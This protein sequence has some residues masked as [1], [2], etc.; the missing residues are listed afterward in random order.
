MNKKKFLWLFVLC[1]TVPL[2][3]A[4]VVLELGWYQGGAGS[5]GDWQRDEVFL[6]PA[7]TDKAHWRL[8]VAPAGDCQQQCQHALYTVQ[9]LYVGLGRKQEQ[10]QPVLLSETAVPA[11]YPIFAQLNSV[12]T[13]PPALQNRILLIDHQ[14]LVLLSYAMPAEDDMAATAKAIRQDLLKLLNYDRTSV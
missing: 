11:N 1:C 12:Q 9:Q 2:L 3:A 14:G 10:V 13:V 4:K 6:L 7:S 5:K 8:A